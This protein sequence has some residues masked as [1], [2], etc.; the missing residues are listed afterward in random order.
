MWVSPHRLDSRWRRPASPSWTCI[1]FRTTLKLGRF[2]VPS[3]RTLLLHFFIRI[4]PTSSHVRPSVYTG[5]GTTG[6]CATMK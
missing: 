4:L 3:V 1:R 6:I 2:E 5:L